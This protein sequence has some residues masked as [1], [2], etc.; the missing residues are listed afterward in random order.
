M[1]MDEN[2][3]ALIAAIGTA[4]QLEQRAVD[5]FDEAVAEKLGVNRTDLRAMDVLF[6]GPMGAGKLA[7]EAGLSPAAMT[8]L[9]DRLEKKGYLRRVRDGVDRRRV[10]IE[11]TDLAKER[12]WELIRPVVEEGEKILADHTTEELVLIR[13]HLILVRE[14]QLRHAERVRELDPFQ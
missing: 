5:A 2:R 3:Q 11:L 7:E 8:T 6:A 13:D 14:C 12:A 10:L 9:I 4:T 1:M